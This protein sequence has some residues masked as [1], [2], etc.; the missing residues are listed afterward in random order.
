[1]TSI[2]FDYGGTDEERGNLLYRGD[3]LVYSPRMSSLPLI[4]FAG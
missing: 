2:I 1:M 3:L 4:E